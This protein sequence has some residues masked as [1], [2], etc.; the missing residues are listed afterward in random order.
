M[1]TTATPLVPGTAAWARKITASKVAA[2]LGVSPY[3]SPLSCWHKMKGNIPLEQETEDHRRG[4][5]AEPAILAWWRDQH[6]EYSHLALQPQFENPTLP[7]AAATPD[8]HAT[9]EGVIDAGVEAKT[10]RSLDDWGTPGTDEIPAYYLVQ[11]LFQMEISGL[12]R[13]YVPVWGS[14]F[15]MAEYVVDYDADLAAGIVARCAEFWASLEAN[16]PPPLDDTLATFQTLKALHPSIDDD[17]VVDLPLDVAREFVESSIDFKAAEARKRAAQSAVLNA[18]GNAQY[19]NHLDTRVARRQ[20]GR[21]DSVSLYVVPKSAD[22]LPS[23][24]NQS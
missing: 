10:A 9:G 2:I 21:G 4:H 11:T 19:G 17:V 22:V 3:D 13:I 14:W 7:W 18:M 12:R 1:T 24:E 16:E 15:E 20:P 23:Q 8:G 6:P 5:Y